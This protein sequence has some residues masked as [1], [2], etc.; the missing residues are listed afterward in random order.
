MR[1]FI[2][3]CSLDEEVTEVLVD[4]LRQA[5]NLRSEDIRCTSLDGYRLPGGAITSE[6]LRKEVNEAALVIG[7]ITPNSIKS[8][9]VLFEL[10]ARWGMEKD[11][12][13]LLA[14]GTKPE[15][16][17]GPLKDINALDC[18]EDG[19][20]HQLIEDAAKYL[21][22]QPDSASSYS[23]PI[24]KLMGASSKVLHSGMHVVTNSEDQLAQ[25][26]STNPEVPALTEEAKL[27]LIKAS[28]DRHGRILKVTTQGGTRVSTDGEEFT[29]GSPRSEALWEGALAQLVEYSLIEDTGSGQV[30]KL[31][32]EGY[33]AADKI[34]AAGSPD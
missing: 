25:S 7:L 1:V 18:S 30:F 34:K 32:H 19:Q 12:I 16:L 14:S 5:L 13:P 9:Y 28:N 15:N 2:S 8:A 11:M 26:P 27:L 23:S 31:T 22:C 10:G 17:E 21:K 3:H 24:K 4:L 6:A 33:T 29:D 20:V